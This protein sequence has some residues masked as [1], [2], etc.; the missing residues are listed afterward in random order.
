MAVLGGGGDGHSEWNS[1]ESESW[2]Q[3]GLMGKPLVFPITRT[4][5]R[6]NYSESLSMWL[7][8]PQVLSTVGFVGS[9]KGKWKLP[10]TQMKHFARQ[11]SSRTALDLSMHLG[12]RPVPQEG[13]VAAP[14]AI[15]EPVPTCTGQSHPPATNTVN[16]GKDRCSP[17]NH[18][19]VH[20]LRNWAQNRNR[21]AGNGQLQNSRYVRGRRRNS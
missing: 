9:A 8:L 15:N 1:P 13:R 16:N 3:W 7:T 20:N 10:T 21:T 11:T 5:P 4:N 12:L 19:T 2:L 6:H 18:R 17:G 14:A